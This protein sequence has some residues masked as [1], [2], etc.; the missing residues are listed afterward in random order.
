MPF[1][2]GLKYRKNDSSTTKKKKARVIA[3][4]KELRVDIQKHFKESRTGAPEGK[5]VRIATWNIRDF[6]KKKY[7]G[8]S[9]EAT[10]YIAEIISNFDILALQEISADLKAFEKLVKILGPSWSYVA[11]DVTDG[12]A[13]NQ[14]RMVF[15]YNTDKVLFRKIAGELTLKENNKIRASFG[16][17]V[18]LENGIKLDIST[19]ELDL[20][21]TYKAYTQTKKGISKLKEDL[22]IK[23][24]EDSKLSLPR[25]SILT[26]KKGTV[27]EKPG[28]G[29]AKV[30]LPKDI[31]EG[32]D[33]GLRFP[34]NSF[35]DSL[36]QFARTP[37]L[38]SFQTGWLKI[39]LCTVH[40]YFGSNDIDKKLKQRQ[41]EI[42]LLVKSLSDKAKNVNE[43]EEGS[44]LG[45]LGDFNIIS[46]GHQTMKALENNG[47]KV[48]DELKK[49]PGSNVKKDKAYDQIA[50][51]NPEEQSR[52]TKLDVKAANVYDFFNVVFN[53]K[54]EAMYREEGHVYNGLKDTHRF[55]T[56]KT[57]KMSDHLPMWIELRT[58]FTEEYFDYLEEQNTDLNP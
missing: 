9:F 30:K 27:I 4:L 58:D 37:F 45:V 8:R 6:G 49:V 24:P 29:K 57:Y 50:F 40:I 15:L 13:G 19:S 3:N 53:K 51:W 16:E 46:S 5:S 32:R 34:E 41:R 38:I 43:F 21:G 18:K 55:D 42:E 7:K 23:L 52:F 10:Y 48:P 33:Y 44:F 25:D 36:R 28:S 35:D 31:I 39:N 2:T 11:T 12:S 1:Y 14:E 54:D 47:F 26:I 20:S 22:E 56:W 17:R